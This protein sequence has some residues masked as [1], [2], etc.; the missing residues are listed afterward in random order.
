MPC[1]NVDD[2][3]SLESMHGLASLSTS[4]VNALVAIFV[5]AMS[6]ANVCAVEAEGEAVDAAGHI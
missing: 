5:H 1:E 2:V 4:D 3:R 6:A